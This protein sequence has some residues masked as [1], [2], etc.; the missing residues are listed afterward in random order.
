MKTEEELGEAA[1]E[2]MYD[3]L[4]HQVKD[5]YDD[6]CAHFRKAIAQARDAANP[7]DAARLTARLEHIAAVFNGQFRGIGT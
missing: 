5:L 3:A 4:P 2:A 7:A 6:A 1:Y